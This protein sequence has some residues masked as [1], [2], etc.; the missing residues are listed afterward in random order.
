MSKTSLDSGGAYFILRPWHEPALALRTSHTLQH[1]YILSKEML[2][3]LNPWFCNAPRSRCLTLA[4]WRGS[5]AQAMCSLERVF[6]EVFALGWKEIGKY[7]PKEVDFGL[8]GRHVSD[9]AYC[10]HVSYD[11]AT[12]LGK[13]PRKRGKSTSKSVS[14]ESRCLRIGEGSLSSHWEATSLIYQISWSL[15]DLPVSFWGRFC[16]LGTGAYLGTR[17]LD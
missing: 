2:G 1:K 10:G 7:R 11:W 9:E 5:T 17:D 16:S 13:S 3:S 6:P 4:C 15:P 8:H 12:L 14:K